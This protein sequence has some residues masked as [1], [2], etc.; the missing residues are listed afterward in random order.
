[1]T[2]VLRTLYPEIEPYAS[3]HLDVGDGHKIYWERS[4]TAGAKPAVFLHG[5]PGGGFSPSHRRLF[6]PALYDVLLFDQRGCGKSTPYADLNANTTWH[7]VADIER[8]REMAGVE[9][10]QVFGGSWGSTLALAYAETYP[11]RVSELV[12]RGIYTLT[13]AE[14]D[15]YYQ[16]GV[17]EMFPDK[18]ERFIAPIPP[19]ERHEMMLAYNRRLTGADRSVAL[20]A[21]QAWSIWE[22]ETITLLPEKSTSGKFEDADFAYAFSRIEN[23]FFVN[24]GWM[25][26]GQLL[27]DAYKLK[28]IP[29][30]IVHGRYDMPCP[31][32]Y[33][34]LLHKAWPQAEFHLIEGAGHAYSEPGIL[35]QLIRA[36]DKFAGKQ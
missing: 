3:G 20:E 4:G 10:W 31:A 34:W 33:A 8:L 11:E 17:S 19:E 22:G 1:M 32:K 28:D 24:A 7:L 2:E 21:A 29:G 14:L 6:D 25:D 27:R 16:F 5:G 12:V 35:D 13:K 18:W 9:K 26:E 36:T 30:V 23:H 15:W